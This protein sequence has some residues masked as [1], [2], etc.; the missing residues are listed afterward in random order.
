MTKEE[1]PREP[2]R[3]PTIAQCNPIWFNI[4]FNARPQAIKTAPRRLEVISNPTGGAH[5][6]PTTNK[7]TRA[8]LHC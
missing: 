4:A 1:G 7:P 6:K 2:E 5:A 8:Q 3:A